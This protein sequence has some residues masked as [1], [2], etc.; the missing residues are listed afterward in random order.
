VVKCFEVNYLPLKKRCAPTSVDAH[1]D[2]FV[3][4]LQVH[5]TFREIG[6]YKTRCWMI[7][8]RWQTGWIY[9]SMIALA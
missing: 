3:I 2:E 6:Y 7:L 1:Q 4:E 9:E 8:V 5:I